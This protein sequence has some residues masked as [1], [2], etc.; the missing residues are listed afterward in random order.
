M[1]PS[2]GSS[3]LRIGQLLGILSAASLALFVYTRALTPLYGSVPTHRYLGHVLK[4]AVG[5]PAATPRL[6][7]SR[8]F[9]LF[10]LLLCAAPNSTYWG[11]V[12]TGRFGDALWGPIATHVAVLGPI[13]YAAASFAIELN[14]SSSSGPPGLFD[15]LV[16][17]QI[18]YSVVTA[19]ADFLWPTISPP[20]VSDD[21]IYLTIGGVVIAI[22]LLSTALA[23]P[24]SS[25]P[26]SAE[27]PVQSK[28]ATKA[29]TKKAAQSPPAK[30][31]KPSADDSI[32]TTRTVLSVIGMLSLPTLLPYLRSPVL[33]H[34]LPDV[35]THPVHPLRILSSTPSTTGVIVVGEVLP[36][37]G[38]T[39]VNSLRY[40][41]ASHSLL[42][43]VW[44]GD[45]VATID[46]V[47]PVVDK[48][49]EPLGDSIYSAFVLQEAARLVSSTA[50]GE[51]DGWN[52]ALIIGLGAGIAAGAFARHDISTTI[53]EID[54]AVYNASRD[55]FGLP[56]LD[57]GRVYL[58]DARQWVS[59]KR[60]E[61]GGGADSLYDIVVHDCFSGGGVP[62]HLFTVE[63]F[64][65]LKSIVHPNGVVAVNFAGK[66]DSDASRAILITLRQHFPQCRAFHDSFEQMTEEKLRTEFINM[67]FF[68]T[69][70]PNP[71][72][73]RPARQGDYLNSYLREHV[74]SSLPQREVDLSQILGEKDP[75]QWVLT[76]SLNSLGEWQK[77]EAFHHWKVMR[78][79]LPDFVWE[80][81]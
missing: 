10:G 54:P 71:L 77:A 66:L 34:P 12:V 49:G 22:W 56:E 31:K 38:A 75:Q 79:V 26:P 39:S 28:P 46:D 24:E 69:R 4:V 29:R 70:S 44:I 3:L 17:L 81:Y 25:S 21:K 19:A 65:D 50:K 33:P 37:D 55:F 48:A 20:E 35:Y 72:T 40:L 58:E 16:V 14:I 30:P 8:A 6:S 23:L 45:R 51:S 78:D 53:V 1:A 74:L 76:D 67:V 64:E 2:L 7:G 59:N 68:C 36:S 52:N 9:L 13:I 27:K 73:F 80:T 41:R 60:A 32:F 43:G 18:F 42:G 63:F 62:E 57:P 15:R 47:P 5:I 61:L 11:A